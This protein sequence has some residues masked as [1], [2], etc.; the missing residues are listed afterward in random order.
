M[1]WVGAGVRPFLDPLERSAEEQG[2]SLVVLKHSL[3]NLRVSP[4]LLHKSRDPLKRAGLRTVLLFG[5]LGTALGSVNKQLLDLRM[6]QPLS[7]ESIG[8]T[9]APG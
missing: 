7:I 9:E 5:A 6:H 3:L 8:P 4:G 2:V 1:E